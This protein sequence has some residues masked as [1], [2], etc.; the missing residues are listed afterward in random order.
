[1]LFFFLLLLFKCTL[2]DAREFHRFPPIGASGDLNCAVGWCFLIKF[3]FFFKT[4]IRRPT[5]SLHSYLARYHSR[6]MLQLAGRDGDDPPSIGMWSIW[7]W[8]SAVGWELWRRRTLRRCSSSSSDVHFIFSL[9]ALSLS[10]S[11]VFLFVFCRRF[12]LLCSG[13][14]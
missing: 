9:R 10:L 8:I 12:S 3:C 6:W 4:K 14:L 11:I 1:M 2:G 5:P 7:K 13:D